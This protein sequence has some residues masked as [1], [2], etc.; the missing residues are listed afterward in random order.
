MGDRFTSPIWG[1]IVTS[2]W[3]SRYEIENNG[4]AFA[5]SAQVRRGARRT[6]GAGKGAL[7]LGPVSRILWTPA[8]AGDR[9]SFLSCRRSLRS[10]GGPRPSPAPKR[11]AAVMRHT[12][13]YRT[14]RPASYFALHRKGFFVPPASRRSAV[15][16]YP[17]FS[18]LPASAPCGASAGG[19]IL[20]DT[21]RR[22]GLTRDA[23]TCPM[24]R[25][26]SCP[27]VSGLSSPSCCGIG[28]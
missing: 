14:G 26:A 15:G 13:G 1:S 28:F 19:I 10:A 2:P 5:V 18:P 21:F 27:A 20:C 12:R 6:A 22:R 9:L 4:G 24:A 8:C 16:S 23:C 7:A 25:A 3:L 11:G 17:T